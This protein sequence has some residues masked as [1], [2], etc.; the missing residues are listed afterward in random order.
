[1]GDTWENYGK[2]FAMTYCVSCHNDDMTGT[3]TRDFHMLSAVIK[4]KSK[5]ACG[6]SK[7]QTDWTMRGC[8]GFPP[9]RQFPVGNG[10]K[11]S[12]AERDRFIKWIDTGTP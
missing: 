6:L 8:S 7:S 1:M 10:A 3:A 2:T 4:E 12:D 11:P 5:I 9:A